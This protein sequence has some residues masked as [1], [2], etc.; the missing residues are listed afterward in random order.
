MKTLPFLV[1]VFGF[2]SVARAQFPVDVEPLI[3]S[4]CVHCHDADTE[5]GLDFS[6][7]EHDL[8]NFETFRAWEKVFD[9]V[10][11][12]E[13]PPESEDR[14]EPELRDAALAA[15]EQALVS[16]SQ[17]RQKQVGRVPARRLTK[18]EL[19]NTLRDLLLIESDVT[20][21]IPDEVESGS[22]DTV[23]SNQRISAVHM[24]SYLRA[25]DEALRLAIQLGENPYRSGENDYSFL[26]EWHDKPLNLGGSVT[27][28]LES[29][30][31]IALFRDIDYLTQF[32]FRVST[33][34]V[35]RLSTKVA[36]YQSKTPVTAKLIVKDQAGGARLEKSVDLE[37]GEPITIVVETYLKPGDTPYITFDM[38]GKE[39][40]NEIIA[41]GGSKNYGGRGMAIMSQKVEGPLFDTWPPPSTRQLLSGLGAE[42]LEIRDIRLAAINSTKPKLESVAKIVRELAPRVFR[43]SVT[44]GE[45]KK[46]VDLAQPA[47]E[48]GRDFIDVMQIPLRSMLSSPQFLLFGGQPGELD[49]FALASRLSYFLWKSM[50]DEELLTLAQ[51]GKLRES[52]VLAEQVERMLRDEKS[53]R[54]VQDFLGQ[55]L[56]LYKVNA[57]TPDDGLYPE[58]DELLGN[59]IPKEPELFF[60]EL[61]D[62][63]LSLTNLIDSDFTFVNRRLAKLYGISS[64]EGQQF[65]KVNL[66]EDSPRGGVL[67]QAAV[68]KTTANGTTTSPV[69][70]GNFVL[71]NFLG[72]P[73]SPPPPGVG[74]IEPDT[75]GKTTIREI[76]AAHREIESCNQCHREIDPPGFALESFDPIGG[77]RTYYRA[78]GGE[79]TFGGF[80]TKLP[81][82]QGPLVD[83]SGMTADGHKFS[84]IK[85]FKQRLLSQKQ[86]L[87][88]NFISQLVVYSTGG[89]IQFADRDEIEG[90][91]NRTAK[92]DY[93]IRDILHEVVQSRL[94]RHK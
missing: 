66:A 6:S 87:A 68:L 89:E 47:I 88:R 34:G 15:L 38:E 53:H 22:F 18:L 63:N 84:G 65:R 23:G 11:A 40:F 64:I 26:D 35:H 57:T 54:F 62:Q 21:G 58:Y 69:T 51:G 31:G 10:Q 44:E 67:T 83:P 77:F 70:R 2:S 39:P 72:T 17:A 52:S 28:R 78:S 46:Y 76:L 33:P 16:A 12:G 48:E 61:I 5:T 4:A 42:G 37:P 7:L 55:W 94:F 59:A 30:D 27:R 56:R 79:Q 49:D 86:Q 85:E 25:A 36:A 13:M 71:T 75:R 32:Q 80:T 60:T 41:A 8:D 1:A 3:Q 93:P 73:P 74:S 20:S 92:D 81:P 50:P 9:R 19:G 90:I 82:K 91:L 29:D 43:R 24:E 14:P 45:L